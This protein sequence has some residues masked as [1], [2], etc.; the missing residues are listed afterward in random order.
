MG[1]PARAGRTPV[2]VAV[3]ANATDETMSRLRSNSLAR[4]QEGE[5]VYDSL[6]DSLQ[7]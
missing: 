2:I 1:G 6:D 7:V 3:S 4:S 5:L